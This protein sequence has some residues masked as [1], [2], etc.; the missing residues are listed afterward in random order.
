MRGRAHASITT[1]GSR[2]LAYLV[3][4]VTAYNTLPERTITELVNMTTMMSVLDIWQ[5]TH[6][7]PR[8][9]LGHC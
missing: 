8:T 1:S 6:R 5:H 2:Q 4:N 9:S 7:A 3:E